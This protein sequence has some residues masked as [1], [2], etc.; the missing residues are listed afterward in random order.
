MS[1]ANESV[2]R[3][4]RWAQL[5]GV[6]GVAFFLGWCWA[7]A[8]ASREGSRPSDPA[9]RPAAGPA[10]QPSDASE[11]QIWTCSMHPQ[12]RRDH[13]GDC[14]ICGMDLVPAGASS[15][16]DEGET[17]EAPQAAVGLSPRARR[18][19]E[20]ETVAVA[21]G[22]ASTRRHL[23]G[24]LELDETKLRSVTAWIGGRIERLLVAATGVEVRRGQ[25]TAVLYSPEVYVAQQD[26]RVSKRQLE[27][28]ESASGSA[29]A[30]AESALRAARRRLELLGVPARDIDR[31]AESETAAT[32]IA[33]RSPVSGTVLERHVT[34]GQYVKTGDPLFRVADLSRLWVQLEAYESELAQMDVGDEVAVRVPALPELQF[35]GRVSFV[36]P[37]VD[38]RTRVAKLRI[39]VEDE[40]G[41]LRPGMYVE[42]SVEGSEGNTEHILVPDGAVIFTG[43]RSL[44]YVEEGHDTPRPRYIP[45]EVVLGPSLDGAW[46]VESGLSEGERVVVEGAFVLDAD[47]Q[48][49]GG[50][51]AMTRRS[52]PDSYWSELLKAYISIQESLAA[53]DLDAAQAAAARSRDA[54]SSLAS[55]AATP[56]SPRLGALESAT[57]LEAARA[58]FERVSAR[59]LEMLDERGNPLS[60]ELRVTHC[61]M[62]GPDGGASWVQTGEEVQN[63]YFGSQMQTCGEFRSVLK[64]GES[65]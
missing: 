14:P 42:A 13:P 50:P 6:A 29:L 37:R 39:E 19:A 65:P 11:A 62:A 17:S 47:L 38:P 49:R 45:R 1:A 2:V 25:R 53:D 3:A 36:E 26:L 60:V 20:L 63:P 31:M 32:E 30:A 4:R 43:R 44:V 52:S 40:A 9:T 57:D 28:M 61:P 51:S 16:A 15:S 58:V 48:I 18:L 27:A 56:L 5:A 24:R 33:I 41:R 64:S 54:A 55:P 12:I 23:L 34:E 35:R 22:Q 46:V 8:D 7:P 10:S 21:S 59:I